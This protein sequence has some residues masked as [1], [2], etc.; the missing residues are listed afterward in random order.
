MVVLETAALL[1]FR[2]ITGRGPKP[3][4]LW[5]TLASGLLLMLALRAA[6]A[7]LRWELIALPLSLALITHIIDLALRWRQR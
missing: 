7:D 3:Q 4:L 1:A 2:R 5:P 6:I